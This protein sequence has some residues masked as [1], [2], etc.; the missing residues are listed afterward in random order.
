VV[1]ED[2][3]AGR[4]S[5]LDQ[6]SEFIESRNEEDAIVKSQMR[7]TLGENKVVEMF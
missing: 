2:V 5:R 4:S 7:Q 6:P 1:L 3:V